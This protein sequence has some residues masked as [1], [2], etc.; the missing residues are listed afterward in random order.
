MSYRIF[1]FLFAVII[2]TFITSCGDNN[3]RS[4]SNHEHS[5]VSD[6]H[7]HQGHD[8]SQKTQ[9]YGMKLD[10]GKKWKMDEHTR[11]MFKKMV[12]SFAA[13]DHTT[14]AGMQKTGNQLKVQINDLIKGC[15]MA[16]NA[17]DQLHVFLTGYI[18]AVELLASSNDLESGS[19]QAIKVKGFLDIYDDFFE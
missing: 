4:S 12:S 16:G 10:S 3:N 5:T 18:P 17:H 13:S 14:V 19:D 9:I 6:D 2:V 11:S 8:H 1:Q 7:S 15:T